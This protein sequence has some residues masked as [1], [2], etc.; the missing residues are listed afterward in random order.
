MEVPV[1]SIFLKYPE[2]V[3]VE[4]LLA[5]LTMEVLLRQERGASW[6]FYFLAKKI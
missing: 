3:A 5:E 4:G 2:K 6:F 1:K